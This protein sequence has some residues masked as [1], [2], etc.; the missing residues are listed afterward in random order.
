MGKYRYNC[1]K[2]QDL[3]PLVV[4]DSLRSGDTRLPPRMG[5]DSGTFYGLQ[6]VIECFAAGRVYRDGYYFSVK[7]G[8]CDGATIP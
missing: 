5:L 4:G 1:G 6:K 8:N 7:M 2:M 3:L